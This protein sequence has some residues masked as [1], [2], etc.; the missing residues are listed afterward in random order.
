MFGGHTKV[1]L[2]L[3]GQR[4]LLAGL[5]SAPGT[6]NPHRS[7]NFTPAGRPHRGTYG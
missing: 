1:T 3:P 4:G 6:G 2:A 7:A 5:P